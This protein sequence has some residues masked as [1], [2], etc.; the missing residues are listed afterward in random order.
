M[1]EVVSND[2]L[3]LAN[4][5]LK[6]GA[7]IVLYYSDSCG[8]CHDFMPVWDE[9]SKKTKKV[10]CAKIKAEF[11]KDININPG[12][13]GVPTVHFY[14]NGKIGNNGEFMEE[15]TVDNLNKFVSTNLIKKKKSK[16]KTKKKS[17]KV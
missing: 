14:R 2:N 5:K 13:I 10:N 17:R 16:K 11:S 6:R 3:V 8:H 15:R 7:W 9:F 1:I 12:F 4:N